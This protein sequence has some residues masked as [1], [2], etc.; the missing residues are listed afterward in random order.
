MQGLSTFLSSKL[1]LDMI[2]HPSAGNFRRGPTYLLLTVAGLGGLLY[3]VDIGI[4]GAALPYL[5]ATSE[6]TAAQLSAVVAAVL[7]GSVLSTLF[8]GLLSDWFGRRTL[9]FVSGLAFT[10]SIPMIALSHSFSSLIAGRLLQGMSAGLIG[11]VVPLYLAECLPASI[12][13]SGTAFFQWFLTLGI[14]VSALVGI[15]YSTRLSE[16]AG[17]VSAGTMFRLQSQAWRRIFWA[18]LPAGV[19]FT[20]GASFVGESPRWLL[21]RGYPDLAYASLVRLRSAYEAGHELTEMKSLHSHLASGRL[22]GHHKWRSIL[23]RKYMVP[24]LLSCAILFCNTASGINS[25]TAYDT[26]LLVQAGLSDIAAHFGYLFLTCIKFLMTIVGIILID[27]AGRKSLLVLGT[28][29]MAISLLA[30][31]G[32]FWKL[33]GLRRDCTRE[34]QALVTSDQSLIFRLDTHTARQLLIASGWSTEDSNRVLLSVVYS[35]GDFTAATPVVRSDQPGQALI[36]ITRL[37][38]IPTNTVEAFVENPFASLSKARVAPLSIHKAIIG[39]VPDARYG[40]AV[41]SFLY[42]F[43]GSYALGPGVCVWLALSELMPTKIRSKGMSVALVINQLAS[44]VMAA[45]FLPVVSRYGYSGIFS[46]FLVFT[47][48]YLAVARFLLPETKGKTLE[49]IEL[50]FEG[51]R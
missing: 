35:Y 26:H 27:K 49:E 5:A 33:E 29:G 25:V 4:I 40:W 37:H 48:A 38:T 51:H 30:V 20:A 6:L 32:I 10:L 19:L 39:R 43:V 41:E 8:T 47:L 16:T 12:R 31:T 14:V 15:Y 13:G 17:V 3:G 18:S 46:L 11:V 22:S 2:G 24:F 7:L 1:S 44:T 36:T 28:T 42:V 34:L 23:T 45:I 9:M 21:Q 50:L